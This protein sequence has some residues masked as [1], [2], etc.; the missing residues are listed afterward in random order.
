MHRAL[1]MLHLEIFE[2]K[3]QFRRLVSFDEIGWDTPFWNQKKPPR[4]KIL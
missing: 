3:K 2:E 1:T 4:F